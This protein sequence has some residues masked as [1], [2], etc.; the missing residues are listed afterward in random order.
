MAT[1]KA[2]TIA[3]PLVTRLVAPDFFPD[4]V[5]AG[6]LPEA[7]AEAPDADGPAVAT[8]PTPPVTTPVLET[9]HFDI[10]IVAGM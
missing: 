3:P 8:A 9:Y 7:E 2:I 10:S 1:A 5:E 4:A 6:A